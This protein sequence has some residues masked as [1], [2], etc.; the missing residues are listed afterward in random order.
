MEA[1]FIKLRRRVHY[2]NRQ[3]SA[4]KRTRGRTERKKEKESL[5]NE[6]LEQREISENKK[7]QWRSEEG[8]M[9]QSV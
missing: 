5:K 1:L 3:K 9:L 7:S 2:A 4:S 6:R 8:G